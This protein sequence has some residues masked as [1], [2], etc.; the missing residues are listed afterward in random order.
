M[1][2]R[3]PE[4]SLED[5]LERS[6]KYSKDLRAANSATVQSARVLARKI[7]SDPESI[8]AA[9]MQ[10][11]LKYCQALGFTLDAKPSKG[12]DESAQAKK[13]LSPMEKFLKSR[14]E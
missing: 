13:E 11:F 2:T 10:T 9:T 4:S 12:D 3:F 7:D 5:A 6:V 14:G 1:A 8:K